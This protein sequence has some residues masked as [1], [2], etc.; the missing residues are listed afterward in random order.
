MTPK[1]LFER[2]QDN[3]Q[4]LVWEGTSNLVF[5]ENIYVVPEVPIQQLPDLISPTA[6]I[7]DKRFVNDTEHPGIGFQNFALTCFV[8]NVSSRFGQASMLDGNRVTNTSKGVGTLNLADEVYSYLFSVT[9]LT[10]KIHILEKSAP[11]PM[12]IKG[13]YPLVTF[14]LNLSAFVSIY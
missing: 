5:G 9:A 11:T 13:N 10:T 4:A 1:Q 12:G 7:V 6:F 14:S 3:L 2:L 8:E